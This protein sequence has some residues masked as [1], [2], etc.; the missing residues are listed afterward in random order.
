[1][2][3]QSF[4]DKFPAI[5]EA[6]TRVVL[7]FE[8]NKFNLPPDDYIFVEIFCNDKKCDCRRV[9]FDVFSEKRKRLEAVI[10]WGWESRDFYKKWLGINDK[11]MITELIGPA[12][13]V[14]SQQSE[15]APALLRLLTESLLTDIEYCN[16]IKR[17]HQ[18]FKK[19][20]L[21]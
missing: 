12:L 3:F 9:F 20:T 2:I 4:H 18:M 15:L 1:M 21:F 6:E 19:K 17:H 8:N 11:E 5:A 14:G 16:R 10:C 7:V 13:N